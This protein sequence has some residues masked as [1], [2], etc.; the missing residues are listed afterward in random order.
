MHKLLRNILIFL[1]IIIFIYVVCFHIFDLKTVIM[2][3]IYPQKYKEYVTLYAEE[4]KLDPLLVFAII[5]TESNFN[6]EAKSKSEARGLMQIMEPTAKEICKNIG[7]QEVS[8]EGLY[9][10]H[11]N[12]QLGTYYFSMLRKEYK[13]IGLALA[14]YNVGIGRVSEW[15]EQDILKQDGSDLENI[16]YKETNMYVRK[17][18]NTYDIYQEL[19]K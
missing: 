6:P 9:N 14:A 18:L 5:K 3:Q 11:N 8:Q 16:P 12:I 15:I 4:Y 17:V 7:I 10:P 2:K 19:Y 13:N 1:V